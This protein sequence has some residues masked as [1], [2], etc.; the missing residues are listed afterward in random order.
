M[1]ATWSD[2]SRKAAKEFVL[3]SLL[4]GSVIFL[5]FLL[6]GRV[7]NATYMKELFGLWV[8]CIVALGPLAWA[9]VGLVREATKW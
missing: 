6:V 7:S 5:I 8:L 1:A 2:N 4:F 3:R 9:V